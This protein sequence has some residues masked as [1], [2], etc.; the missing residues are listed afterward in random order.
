MLGLLAIVFLPNRPE[1]T[2]FLNEDERRIAAAR[3]TRGISGDYGF[4]INKCQS[5]YGIM[6]EH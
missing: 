4:V 5:Q 3:R 6:Q 2:A 1:M